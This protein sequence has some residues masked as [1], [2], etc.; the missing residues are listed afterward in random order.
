[1]IQKEIYQNLTKYV[2]NLEKWQ[3][4]NERDRG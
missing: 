1:M 3:N 4:L 2:Q